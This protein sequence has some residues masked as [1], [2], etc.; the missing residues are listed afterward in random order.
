MDWSNESYVR[1]YTRDTMT[2]EMLSWDARCVFMALLRKV[3]RAGVVDTNSHGIAGLAVLLRC[4]NKTLLMNAINELLTE[5]LVTTDGSVF[6][7]PNFIEAQEASKANK[8]SQKESREKKRDLALF[9]KINVITIDRLSQESPGCHKYDEN[10]ITSGQVVTPLLCFALPPVP[11]LKELGESEIKQ[12][13][14]APL[15][16][17]PKPS[18]KPS[19]KR[20][21]DAKNASPPL[22][23]ALTDSL[24]EAFEKQRN[25]R[26]EFSVKDG[27]QLSGLW[28]KESAEE[29]LRR[30]RE[31]LQ[32]TDWYR[33]DT[34]TQL[35]TRWNELASPP[36]NK[37]KSTF[38]QEEK[39]W[40]KIAAEE[41]PF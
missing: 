26:Y 24:C 29:I 37:I 34:V 2:W 30:W 8:Q 12:E 20:A 33:V 21:D 3:D 23:R 7:I 35:V 25:S 15:A 9:N 1:L 32:R 11:A 39:D 36:P 17:T 19:G 4:P 31:G 10:V 22:F 38:A 14:S 6:V 27:V 40:N 18:T 13:T 28:K 41:L 5:K 16:K